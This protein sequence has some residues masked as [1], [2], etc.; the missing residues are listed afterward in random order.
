MRAPRSAALLCAVLTAVPLAGCFGPAPPGPL[1]FVL[2]DGEGT[3]VTIPLEVRRIISLTPSHTEVVFALGLG[4]RVV[5]VTDFDTYPPEA[6]SI[7]H[8]LANLTVN[9]ELVAAAD[10]DIILVSSLNNRADIDRLRSLNYSVFFADALAVRDVPPMIRLLG[11][12]VGAEA[13][14][15]RV[16]G[17]LEAAVNATAA[18][19]AR[20]STRPRT[21]YL[22]DDFGGY[23]TA[24]AGTRG[25]DLIDLAGGENVFSNVTG[26]SSVS[27]EAIAATGPEV[28]ILGLYVSL[29]QATMNVTAPWSSA[30][31]VT[32]GRVYRV[33]DADIVDRPGPRLAQ[34]LAWMLGAV[35]PEL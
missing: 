7:T 26:W 12:A 21:F 34:G 28:I 33:P 8:V 18:E 1:T 15:S 30:P 3:S 4:S 13:N 20:A 29:D 10:P 25:D 5:G 24:G 9:L 27:I 14:A 17:E 22:L 31:A 16:A 23:W 32:A 2:A 11:K 19:A 35:H 6:A